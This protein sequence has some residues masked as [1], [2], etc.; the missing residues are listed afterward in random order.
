[1]TITLKMTEK[2]LEEKITTIVKKVLA[3]MPAQPNMTDE[4]RDEWITEFKKIMRE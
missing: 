4:E 2:Q 1:M 3:D